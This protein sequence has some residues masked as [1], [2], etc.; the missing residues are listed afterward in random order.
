MFGATALGVHQL[1]PRCDV[2]VG[3][4]LVGEALVLIL[5]SDSVLV[6]TIL[7]HFTGCSAV[8]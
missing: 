1:G 6:I 7:L 5:S 3:D 2:V 4:R 8:C